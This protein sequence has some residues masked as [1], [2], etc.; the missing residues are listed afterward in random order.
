VVSYSTWIETF[1]GADGLVIERYNRGATVPELRLHQE[2]FNQVLGASGA[3]KV[4]DR[5]GKVTRSV[6][7]GN[8]DMQA[9]NL[10]LLRSPW[11]SARLAPAD[12]MFVTV[13]NRCSYSRLMMYP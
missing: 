10:F 5:G 8:L 1:E 4:Q 11:G 9:K 6:A 3:E 13:N 12:D 2:D 7:V